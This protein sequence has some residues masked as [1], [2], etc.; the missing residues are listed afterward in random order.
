VRAFATYKKKAYDYK[1]L[2]ADGSFYV[3]LKNKEEE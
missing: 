3:E 1:A 2:V